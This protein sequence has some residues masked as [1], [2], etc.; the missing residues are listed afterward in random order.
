MSRS[1]GRVI[2]VFNEGF[3]LFELHATPKKTNTSAVAV[4][5]LGEK[6]LFNFVQDQ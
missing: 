1:F 5:K 4:E 3:S 6:K 2:T